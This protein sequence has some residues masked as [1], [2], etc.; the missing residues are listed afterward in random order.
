MDHLCTRHNYIYIQTHAYGH[1]AWNHEHRSEV[2]VYGVCEASRF[3][4]ISD[5]AL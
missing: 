3:R 5:D 2:V 4:A 1:M